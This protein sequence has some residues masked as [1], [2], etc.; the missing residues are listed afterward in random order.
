MKIL[1]TAIAA[2]AIMVSHS[3]HAQWI[4]NTNTPT[5]TQNQNTTGQIKIFTD[6]PTAN[7]M[8]WPLFIWGNVRHASGTNSFLGGANILALNSTA[9]TT[10]TGTGLYVT[11]GNESSA[12]GTI[13]TA[14]AIK[15]RVQTG[16]GTVTNG[17]GVYIENTAAVNDWGVYQAGADDTNYFAGNIAVGTTNPGS[18]K[19]AVEGKIGAREVQ[20]LTTNPFPDYVFAPDYNLISLPELESFIK[21]NKHLP[22]MPTA[23]EIKNDGLAL[24]KVSTVLVE[25]VEEL[26]LYVIELE[27]LRNE[28]A[29]QLRCQTELM[30]KLMAEIEALKKKVN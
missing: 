1:K 8:T 17:Y 16:L 29:E 27:K 24:G 19:L 3:L 2:M 23:T 4:V 11:T 30:N 21:I 10:T 18:F 6:F 7:T 14:Y 22:G 26:T 20:V 15:A 13:T 5:V 9:A 12:T 28:Q 25:K